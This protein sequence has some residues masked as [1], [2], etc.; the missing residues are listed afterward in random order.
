MNLTIVFHTVHLKFSYQTRLSCISCFWT[1]I[2]IQKYICNMKNPIIFLIVLFA[3]FNISPADAQQHEPM[4]IEISVSP[5]T[6]STSNIPLAMITVEVKT[7]NPAFKYTLY[8]NYPWDGGK[9]I[10]KSDFSHNRSYVFDNI[11]PGTYY[12][13]VINEDETGASRLIT[14]ND[15]LVILKHDELQ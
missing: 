4:L 13:S 12:V 1:G 14:V 7:G 11:N 15:K 10:A 9:I 6:L 3:A 5:G 2:S 8:D